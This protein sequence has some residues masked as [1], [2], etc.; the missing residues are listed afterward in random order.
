M[1][2]ESCAR[3]DNVLSQWLE[4]SWE[5]PDRRVPSELT[6]HADHCESCGRRLRVALRLLGTT[7]ETP[8]GLADSVMAGIGDEE[9][10]RSFR[11]VPL[12]AAAAFLLVALGFG[13]F[14]G[15]TR[16]NSVTVELTLHAPQASRVAVVGGW[17]D[18]DATRDP[19]SDPD[20]DGLWQIK[21]TL[22]AGTE[23]LY[24]FVIDEEMRIADPLALINLDDG[25][26]SVN[27]VMN[28]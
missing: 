9:R 15:T 24:Q 5:A 17:N 14:L 2:A 20:G 27:S 10:P 23:H 6:Q 13:L 28:L 1:N 8:A 26:G 11:R 18:W 3:F 12:L 16:G 7:H 19:M 4:D 21:L 25:F 22:K